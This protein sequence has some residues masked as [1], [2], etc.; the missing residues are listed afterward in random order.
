MRMVYLY[1]LHVTSGPS[2]PGISPAIA[3][4]CA[5]VG[6]ERLLRQAQVEWNGHLGLS[7]SGRESV[8]VRVL[9]AYPL[10]RRQV[11]PNSR[12]FA[13]NPG[14]RDRKTSCPGGRLSPRLM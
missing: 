2:I 7:C 14:V 6:E 9:P 1:Y 12:R 11:A 8:M 5:L 13:S 10:L 3:M 4:G